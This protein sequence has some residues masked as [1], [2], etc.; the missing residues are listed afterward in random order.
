M[1]YYI[2]KESPAADFYVAWDHGADGPAYGG[3][4]AEMVEFLYEESDLKPDRHPAGKTP[5][6]RL[7]RADETGT[8]ARH[9]FGGEPIAGSW[10]DPTLLVGDI[11][12]GWAMVPRALVG[13]LTRRWM[14]VGWD[15]PDLSG[16]DITIKSDEE[17]E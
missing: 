8:S 5:E 6:D 2:I 4:R 11:C 12:G 9:S 7:A 17:D 14:A 13:E 15:E 3:S 10:E 1:T 16:L